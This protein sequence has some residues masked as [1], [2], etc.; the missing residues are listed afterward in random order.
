MVGT[1]TQIVYGGGGKSLT[2][3]FLFELYISRRTLRGYT[4][5]NRLFVRADYIQLVNI[6][7]TSIL[8]VWK[9]GR[10]LRSRE[11]K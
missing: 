9:R 11:K 8:K 6:G 2:F 10:G 3:F 7:V 1:Q 5:R 4:I